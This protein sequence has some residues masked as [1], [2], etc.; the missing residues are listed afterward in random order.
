[1]HTRLV[2]ESGLHSAPKAP[3]LG[4][5]GNVDM[6]LANLT[7]SSQGSLKTTNLPDKSMMPHLKHILSNKVSASPT[8]T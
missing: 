5:E 2:L 6:R 8:Q 3:V 1:M 7:R 4:K